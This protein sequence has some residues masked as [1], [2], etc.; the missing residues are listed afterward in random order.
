VGADR[1]ERLCAEL[2]DRRTVFVHEVTPRG[3]GD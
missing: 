3:G 2:G 1:R